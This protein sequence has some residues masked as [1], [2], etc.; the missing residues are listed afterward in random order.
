MTAW[1]IIAITAAITAIAPLTGPQRTQLATA[2][3]HTAQIDEAALYPLLNNALTWEPGDEAGATIPDYNALRADPAAH[4]GALFLIEGDFAGGPQIKIGPLSRRGLWDDSLEQWVIV[5]D[6]AADEVAVVYLTDPP[7]QPLAGTPIRVV[8]RFYKILDDFDRSNPPKP[9]QYLTFIGRSVSDATTT[10]ASTS[11]TSTT[12]PVLLVFMLAGAWYL[13]RKKLKATRLATANL[14]KRSRR[15][16][17]DNAPFTTHETNVPKD[18]VAA[19]SA[20]A[21]HRDDD[22]APPPI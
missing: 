8:A 9:T 15:S 5:T 1:P 7:P 3:D 19:L 21:A 12:A 18:P 6:R 16:S 10:A 17:T 20:L 13:A 14:G 11:N 4:R 22:P 2:T